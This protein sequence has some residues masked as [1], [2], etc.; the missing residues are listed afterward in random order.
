MSLNIKLEVHHPDSAVLQYREQAAR[1]VLAQFTELP[2]GVRTLCF[3]DE[4]DCHQI[5][6]TGEANRGLSGPVKEPTDLRGWPQNV[7]QCF[8][9]DDCDYDGKLL[10]DFLIYL[11]DSSCADPIGSTMTFA[12]ELQHLV[13]Y[14][15]VS[16]I[17][18][19]N[20]RFK[21]H[22]KDLQRHGVHQYQFPLEH[23]ARLVAKQIAIKI[24]GAVDVERYIYCNIIHPIDDFDC[25]NWKFIRELDVSHSYDV[26]AETEK[27]AGLLG[28][29][30]TSA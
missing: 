28:L 25:D 23:E 10:F 1:K 24:H 14:A 20:E 22:Q 26:T 15:S 13:Q 8:F 11:H 2:S 19:L 6:G 9:R 21:E 30:G 4:T 7:V 3:F 17:W 27:V 18:G 5:L 12:H 29:A 16:R